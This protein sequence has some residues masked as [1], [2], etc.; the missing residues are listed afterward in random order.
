MTKQ[1]NPNENVIMSDLQAALDDTEAVLKDLADEGSAVSESVRDR[2][3]ANLKGVKAKLQETEA[4][5]TDKAKE[6]ARVTDEYVRENPWQTI[7]IAAGVGFLLGLLV[8][9]RGQ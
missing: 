5:V 9:R 3:S 1:A 2:I 8:S 6:A 7:G 4:L